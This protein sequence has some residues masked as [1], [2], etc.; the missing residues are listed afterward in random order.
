MEKKTVMTILKYVLSI[1]LGAGLLWLA[2]RGVNFEAVKAGFRSADYIWV[3]LALL[4]VLASHALRA[5]RWQILL[6]AAGYESR[7][8]HLF[9]SVMVGIMVNKAIPRAGE[10]SRASLSAQ[11]EKIPLSTSLG[12]LVTDRV[13]D[14]LV[15]GLLVLVI[16]VPQMDD[17]AMIFEGQEGARSAAQSIFARKWMLV[18]L[19]GLPVLALSVFLI[20]RKTI[21]TTKLF[22]AIQAFIKKMWEAMKSVRRMENPGRF[23]MYTI[24]IWLGYFFNTYLVF[25]AL[26]STQDLSVFFVLTAFTMGTIGMVVPTPGG[27]GSYHFA[28]I[29][30]FVAFADSLGFTEESARSAGTSIAFIIHT[31]QLIMVLVVGFLSYL[32]LLPKLRLAQ[33]ETAS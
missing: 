8:L 18:V 21:V 23:I 13:F 25:L 33:R 22:R 32:Y 30:T 31:A 2:V 20:F 4:C 19:I 26:D 14:V 24:G 17:L 1:A 16:L 7:V 12:T 11:T 27:I 6:K 10:L 5:A 9:A 28:I 29:M 15:L 3:G